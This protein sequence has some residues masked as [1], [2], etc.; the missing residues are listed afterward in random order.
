M[1]N[2]NL[3]E[4]DNFKTAENISLNSVF[5]ILDDE[6]KNFLFDEFK[7][8]GAYDISEIIERIFNNDEP[9]FVLENLYNYEIISDNSWKDIIINRKIYEMQKIIDELNKKLEIYKKFLTEVIKAESDVKDYPNFAWSHNER[10]DAY[11]GLKN[12]KQAISDFTEAIKLSPNFSNAYYKRGICYK[13]IG[14]NEKAK[15]DF[16]KY[17]E[18]EREFGWKG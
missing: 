6:V 4:E 9:R 16:K 18:L 11:F 2:E 14:E 12:Y 5:K 17:R 10:G 7:N 15:K 13:E 8:S 3:K 1:E